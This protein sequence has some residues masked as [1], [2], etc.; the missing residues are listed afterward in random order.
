MQRPAGSRC[1]GHLDALEL[2]HELRSPG[3]VALRPGDLAE[4]HE[5]VGLVGTFR[6]PRGACGFLPDLVGA[7]LQPGSLGRRR[8]V[9]LLLLSA[10]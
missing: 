7:A 4:A 6:R 9:R 5:L 10:A 2:P 1:V 8:V 3:G